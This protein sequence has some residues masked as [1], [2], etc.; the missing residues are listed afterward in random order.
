MKFIKY[1]NGIFLTFIVFLLGFIKDELKS[2]L[3]ITMY[4]LIIF[5]NGVI[6]Y[7]CREYDK[8]VSEIEKKEK[9]IKILDDK[10]TCAF[11]SGNGNSPYKIQIYIEES[12]DNSISINNEYNFIILV[13]TIDS[14]C[15]IKYINLDFNER[16]SVKQTCIN[17]GKSDYKLK[18][19]V[20]TKRNGKFEYEFK[21]KD[22]S[23]DR[24]F[25]IGKCEFT[26]KH[27]KSIDINTNIEVCGE[28]NAI[29]RKES[30]DIKVLV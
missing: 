24:L 6:I 9:E 29:S 2:W 11:L 17:L 22:E 30:I 3:E 4:V 27:N 12:K 15:D 21:I 8:K 28:N 18:S 26:L 5:F 14:S 1:F 19:Q 10:L 16:V 13:S 7:V 23:Q 20:A 25:S